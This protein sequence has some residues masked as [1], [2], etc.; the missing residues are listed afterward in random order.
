MYWVL[1]GT[2]ARRGSLGPITKE[3]ERRADPSIASVGNPGERGEMRQEEVLF[4]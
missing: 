2:T 1:G 3:R 4:A